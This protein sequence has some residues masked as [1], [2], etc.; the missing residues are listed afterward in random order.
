MKK[1]IVFILMFMLMFTTVCV[2]DTISPLAVYEDSIT[3]VQ[4]DTEYK[5][6]SLDNGLCIYF[7]DDVNIAAE[8]PFGEHLNDNYVK[9]WL[10][11]NGSETRQFF[12]RSGKWEENPKTYFAP[13]IDKDGKAID[14]SYSMNGFYEY[15]KSKIEGEIDLLK[16]TK[17]G[18][19]QEG[20][21]Y[22]Y[23]ESGDKTYVIPLTANE[24][25]E[26]GLV[27]GELYDAETA[28]KMFDDKIV[29]SEEPKGGGT[30][31][32]E[33]EQPSGDTTGAVVDTEEQIGD[34]IDTSDD[35]KEST[36]DT[37]ELENDVAD[38]A[39]TESVGAFPEKDNAVNHPT[40]DDI[41]NEKD[42]TIYYVIGG[43]AVVIIALVLTLSLK[44]KK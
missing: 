15:A 2:A 22:I 4:Q 1:I 32:E 19:G 12:N 13:F 29:Y 17:R 30:S 33:P 6:I 31:S 9:Y 43:A 25:I 24:Y 20:A 37:N 27:S 23:F 36:E 10:I 35:V 21:T 28:K 42:Y 40:A 26:C 41:K 8:K 38:D 16:I 7:Y 18:F 5:E 34:T 44:K 11:P 3:E 14:I 39:I